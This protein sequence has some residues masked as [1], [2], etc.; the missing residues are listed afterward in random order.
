MTPLPGLAGFAIL[1]G[2]VI[3]ARHRN[4]RAQGSRAHSATQKRPR[5]GA[6]AMPAFWREDRFELA[7][8][9]SLV[10]FRAAELHRPGFLTTAGRE[11]DHSNQQAD[12]RDF[13]SVHGVLQSVPSPKLAQ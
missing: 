6:F 13:L 4:G 8:Y 3:L 10:H 1:K 5:L 11:S 9:L 2:L 7:G 12:N